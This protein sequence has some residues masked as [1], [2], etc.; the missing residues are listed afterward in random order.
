MF[1]WNRPFFKKYGCKW[2][3]EWVREREKYKREW[4]WKKLKDIGRE[5][6]KLYKA[7]KWM[8]GRKSIKMI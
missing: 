4:A 7:K 8:R 1:V 5:R 3:S 2:M 6:K